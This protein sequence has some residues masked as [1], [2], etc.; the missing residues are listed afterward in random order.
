MKK[1]ITIMTMLTVCAAAFA[2]NANKNLIVYFSLYGNQKTTLTDA[3]TEASRMMYNGKLCGNTEVIAKMIQE[4]VGGDVVLIETQNKFSDGYNAVL[5]EGKHTKNTKYKATTT[6][7][8]MSKYDN[9]FIGF[10]AWWYDM[11]DP[12]FDFLDKHDLS[13]KNVYVFATSGGSGL[14]RSVSEIQAA[15]PKASVHKS[16]FH[17]YYTGTARA[18][19][20]VS[21]WLKNVGAK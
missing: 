11:P 3:V 7:V 6:K 17:V 14:M 18:K 13:G 16:G 5:E 12:I 20:D 2:Q 21:K 19:A 4:E 15:E 10:P 8:D 9:V 1:I